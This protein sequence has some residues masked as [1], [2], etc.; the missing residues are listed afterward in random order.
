MTGWS[1]RM[2]AQTEVAKLILIHGLQP[3][4]SST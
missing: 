2:P 3:N 1:C 4:G